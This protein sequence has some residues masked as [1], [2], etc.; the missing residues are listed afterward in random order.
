MPDQPDRTKL[1]DA[2]LALAGPSLDF[3]GTVH[4][5]M[6]TGS[7][8]PVIPVGCELVI[9]AAQRRPFGV[10]DVV[11]F[12]R[13]DRL[14]A[15][16]IL[17]QLGWGPHALIFEKGDLNADAGWIRRRDVRGVVVGRVPAESGTELPP[18][19]PRGIV[20]RSLRHGVRA[21]LRKWLGR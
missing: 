18:L 1:L 14:V 2:W 21:T 3:G 9:A 7:M 8:L 11:I 5:P 12:L 6:L 15:H 13:D 20:G 17:G 16:R 4:L 10:G 19:A